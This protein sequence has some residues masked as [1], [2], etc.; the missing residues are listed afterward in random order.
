[1]GA[2][3]I[4]T[5]RTLAVAGAAV[6]ALVAGALPVLAQLPTYGLGRAPTAEVVKAWD[7]TIPPD[8]KGLPPGSGTVTLGKAV[9][10]E[11]CASCHGPTGEDPKYNVLVGGRGTLTTD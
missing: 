2:S 8:G 6:F 11:R 3:T 7:L 4:S 10:T 1:M 5:R 9:Y